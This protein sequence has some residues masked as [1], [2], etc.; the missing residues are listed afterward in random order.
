MDNRKY[1]ALVIDRKKFRENAEF[2]CRKCYEKGVVV[3]GV[4]KGFNG[5]T[6]LAEEYVAG[7]ASCI[8]SSRLEQ[9]EDCRAAG[10]A[11]PLMMIRVPMLSEVDDVVRV[12]DYSLNSELATLVALNEA[13][14]EQEKTHRV[15]LMTDLGDLREGWI[16]YDEFVKVAELVEN[17]FDALEL[18]GIGTNL[19]CYGSVIPTEEKM[20][21][22]AELAAAIE[23]KIGRSLEIISGGA[24]SSMLRIFEGD[25]PE[26]IN[27][28]RIGEAVLVGPLGDLRV[29]YGCEA[30]DEMN[31]DV[32]VLEAEVIEVKTKP[33]YPIGELGVDAFGNKGEY[34]D[35]GERRR[36]LL[37]IGRADYVDVS[38][39]IPVD[40]GF[41]PV[42]ASG[43]HTILDITD[44]ERQ[45]QV[46]DIVQLKLTYSAILALSGSRNVKKY[47]I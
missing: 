28:L 47:F 24:T 20:K 30:V 39:L 45:L 26:K 40:E 38:K 5:F 33:S 1:P 42:G 36:A 44:A 11:V 21:Q 43:D 19:G 18:A 32:C 37:A 25:M 23:T 6:E 12:A 4:I 10:I 3:T 31:D 27:M 22:L 7:G 16:D 2:I 14:K 9:L 29:A 46:G 17:E 41:E 35:R 13:A 8:A 34:V 15:I